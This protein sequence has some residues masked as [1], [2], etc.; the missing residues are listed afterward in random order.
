MIQQICTLANYGT[1]YLSRPE[2]DRLT[3]ILTEY[4]FNYMF[5]QDGNIEVEIR[6]TGI[7]QVYVKEDD[8]PNPFG[9]TLAP[10]IN[11]HYHQHI[12]SVRVDPMVDGLQNTVVETDILPLSNAPTGHAANHLGNAFITRGTP[13][14]VA[15]EGARDFDYEKDRRWSIINPKVVHPHSKRNAG[16]TIM[17]KGAAT[18]LMAL[19]ESIVAKR[20]PFATKPLWVVKDVEG[21]KGG[22][23]WPS[24]KYVP[25]T[26]EAPEDSLSNWAKGSDSL[27]EEDI[28]LYLTMGA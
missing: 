8:E 23:V 9:S 7:V 21:P 28:L 12:F 15:S 1:L 14:A 19:P 2:P 5:Y 4:I 25:Q 10:G 24:G 11:A 17:G 20:A 3:S 18:P 6:L 13:V 22:R 27:L 26:R 16:Y